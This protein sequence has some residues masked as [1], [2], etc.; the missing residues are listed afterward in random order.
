MRNANPVEG[1]LKPCRTRHKKITLDILPN[2]HIGQGTMVQ[3]C[4]LAWGR[5]QLLS[6]LEPSKQTTVA[7]S[8]FSEAGL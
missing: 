2:A 4:G 1:N 3:F 5:Q 8:S 6:Q 7:L